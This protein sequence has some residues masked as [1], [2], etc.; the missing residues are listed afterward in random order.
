ML[1]CEDSAKLKGVMSRVE[2]LS[3][4]VFVLRTVYV[5][6]RDQ[7]GRRRGGD[8]TFVDLC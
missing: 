7:W 4:E 2:F 5:G 6:A 3:N 8:I 1:S